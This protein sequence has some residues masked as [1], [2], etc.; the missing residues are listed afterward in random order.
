MERGAWTDQRLDDFRER[1]ELRFDSVENQMRD[2][3]TRVDRELIEIRS[4]I[5]GIQTTLIQ[6]GGRAMIALGGVIVALIGVI[7]AVLTAS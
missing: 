4:E 2:G 1:V 3:F 6:F 7:A 5:A